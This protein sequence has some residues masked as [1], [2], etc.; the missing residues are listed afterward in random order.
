M[1]P[2]NW[3]NWLKIFSLILTVSCATSE[4]KKEAPTY[5]SSTEQTFE[6]IERG[7]ALDYYRQLRQR[8]NPARH[9]PARPSTIKPKPYVQ[10]RERPVATP[11]PVP[12]MTAEQKEAI[13]TEIGQNLSYFC[14]LNRKDSRFSDE[15]EC[16]AYTQNILH[17]CRARVD[18]NEGRKLVGC[19]KSNLKL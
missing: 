14:M 7:R 1:T 18:E 8:G 9:A 11:R 4:N 6:E 3:L 15:A 19:V 17:D 2:L 13:E 5:S 16:H 10:R 12:Q